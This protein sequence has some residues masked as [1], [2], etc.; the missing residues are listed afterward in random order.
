MVVMSTAHEAWLLAQSSRLPQDMGPQGLN[1]GILKKNV[2]GDTK[3]GPW[4]S[5]S[6]LKALG[7]RKC[8]LLKWANTSAD[9]RHRT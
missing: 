1:F 9:T 7:H 3:S 6:N 5:E 2:D 4:C 8:S